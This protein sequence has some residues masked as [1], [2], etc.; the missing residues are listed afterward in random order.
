M[1]DK[2]SMSIC[3]TTEYIGQITSGH[4]V[5]SYTW[6]DDRFDN[7]LVQVFIRNAATW[8]RQF[9]KNV[10]EGT[11]DSVCSFYSQ[12]LA[13]GRGFT[14]K[15]GCRIRIHTV[16][17]TR[18]LQLLHTRVQKHCAYFA[19]KDLNYLAHPRYEFESNVEFWP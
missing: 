7:N 16:D 6:Y 18:I 11:N 5:L 2:L 13:Y 3:E 8:W 4:V 17:A 9:L 14:C 15:L 10:F 19:I 1:M 12:S